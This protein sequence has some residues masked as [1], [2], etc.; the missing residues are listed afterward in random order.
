MK[1]T[2]KQNMLLELITNFHKACVSLCIKYSLACGTA[3]GAV[4]E[5]GFIPWDDDIDIMMR[6]SDYLV[7]QNSKQTEF[8]W[9]CAK[10]EKKS[11]VILARVYDKNVDYDHLEA[12]P[13][14]D[15]HVY[16]GG[17]DNDAETIRAIKITDFY[18]KV[19]WV[20]SRRYH[21]IL[22]RKKSFIGTLCKIPL[23]VVSKK[24]CVATMI[25]YIDKW[26]YITAKKIFPLQGYYKEKEILPKMWLESYVL[27]QFCGVELYVISNYDAY[28]KQLYGD[29][30]TPVRY[31]RT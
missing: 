28:L 30:M 20:K 31:K 11:P 16:V 5:H 3:L 26:D 4:R 21:N 22:K 10:N 23:L 29:Y 1:I 7:M 25:K 12:F 6:Y 2:E 24:K 18:A 19:Y 27:L 14:I 9:V 15:I 8:K 17:S 13:Y